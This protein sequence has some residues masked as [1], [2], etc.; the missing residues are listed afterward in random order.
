MAFSLAVIAEVVSIGKNL[1]DFID[2]V[3][4]GTKGFVA[5]SRVRW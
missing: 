5:K 4:S 3:S 1:Y 2:K